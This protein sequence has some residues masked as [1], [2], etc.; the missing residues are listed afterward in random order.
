VEGAL[1]K[2][3][4]DTPAAPKELLDDAIDTSISASEWRRVEG[5]LRVTISERLAAMCIKPGADA[6]SL[7]GLAGERVD[8]AAGAEE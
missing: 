5:L 8:H 6:S 1:D 4:D 7:W 2:V 3:L